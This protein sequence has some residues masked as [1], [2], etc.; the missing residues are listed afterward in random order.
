[1]SP[2]LALWL[3]IVAGTAVSLALLFF[4]APP[5][6]PARLAWPVAGVTGAWC[7]VLL[8]AVLARRRPRFPPPASRWPV[9]LGKLAFLGLW[10]ANEE[11]V[12]RRVAAG[13]L[14][15]DGVVPAL[16]A[17]TAGFAFVHSG[18]RTVHLG[19]GGMFG[20]L[21]LSTGVLVASIAAHWTYNVLVGGLVDRRAR[22]EA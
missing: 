8:F 12:W 14:L 1:V 7:G 2:R 6:P 3:R 11:V 17:S 4:L 13:E 22:G 15:H 19:T 16:A 5:R 18:R 21:Y 9:L 20:A 10:A